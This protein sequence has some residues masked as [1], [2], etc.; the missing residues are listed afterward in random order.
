MKANQMKYHGMSQQLFES[1]FEYSVY[2]PSNSNL[3]TTLDISINKE[4]LTQIEKEIE[5]D[6]SYNLYM[7][8]KSKYEALDFAPIF[9]NLTNNK[10]ADSKISQDKDESSQCTE[11]MNTFNFNENSYEINYVNNLK[12]NN[13]LMQFKNELSLNES[14]Y[15]EELLSSGF[16]SY[17]E[18]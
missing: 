1:N 18:D 10:L 6:P 17:K 4:K 7:F 16:V 8:I 2:Y 12:Q 11:I 15:K 3:T 9:E 14:F 13:N 5:K